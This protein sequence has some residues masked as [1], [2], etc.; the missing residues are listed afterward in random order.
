MTT[1][2]RLAFV[3]MDEQ[4]PVEDGTYIVITKNGAIC[5]TRWVFGSWNAQFKN[6]VYRWARISKDT[7]MY[8][9]DRDMFGNP[10]EDK[11]NG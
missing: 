3:R 2:I 6:C 8:L 11:A 7:L 4:K 9:L 5:T 10:K 1:T